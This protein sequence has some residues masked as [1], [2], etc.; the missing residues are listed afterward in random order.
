[1]IKYFRLTLYTFCVCSMLGLK[2]YAELFLELLK[3]HKSYL[4]IRRL[5]YD[6]VLMITSTQYA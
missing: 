6:E 3:M 4:E 1:M 2:I 5:S